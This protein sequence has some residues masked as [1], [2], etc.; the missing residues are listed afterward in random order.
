MG[1][2][3]EDRI[4]WIFFSYAEKQVAWIKEKCLAKYERIRIL[5]LDEL[6]L[7]HLIFFTTLRKINFT[8]IYKNTALRF[9]HCE[10]RAV[11][12]LAFH[13]EKPQVY[14]EKRLTS[15]LPARRS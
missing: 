12:D 10:S 9:P 6:R 2:L 4:L 11:F 13:R 5:K 7:I 8:A 15:V 14:R 1:I 3:Y